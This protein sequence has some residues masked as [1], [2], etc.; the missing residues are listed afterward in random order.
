MPY[1]FY[2]YAS[3]NLYIVKRNMDSPAGEIPCQEPEQL[4]D[5][6]HAIKTEIIPQQINTGSLDI[7]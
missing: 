7:M 4:R 3:I 5:S 2:D 1:H 6:D